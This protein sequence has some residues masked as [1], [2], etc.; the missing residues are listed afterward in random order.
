MKDKDTTKGWGKVE[1]D[2]SEIW[3][4]KP[5]FL[6]EKIEFKD[7]LKLLFYPKKWFLYR[8]IK[9][10]IRKQSGNNLAVLDVGCGTGASLVD[11]KKM[12]GRG[13]KIVGVDV[14]CLQVDLAKEKIK[15]NGVWAE[16][17][18][19]DGAN[20]PFSD[21]TFD[22]IYTSDVLG[23]V[24]NVESWLIELNRVLKPGGV[25]AMFSESKLGRHAYVRNYLMKNGLN[26]DPHA[27][28][29]ISLYSKIMLRE[30]V[31]R[32]GFEIKKMKSVF[33]ASFLVHPDEFYDK[34]QK[35]NPERA[36]R[37]EGSRIQG[38]KQRDASTSS[39][40]TSLSIKLLKIINKILYKIKKILHPVST[41]LCEL[42]GLVEI[43]LVGRF[44]ES[45]GYI[46]F[47][48]KTKVKEEVEE[49]L[50]KSKILAPDMRGA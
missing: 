29:H 37:V 17:H 24:E 21:D 4:T 28:Y 9:S 6:N 11:L 19:Y 36:K 44:I 38:I 49:E 5:V 8:F 7:W 39:F 48:Q 12:F 3:D 32:A 50:E 16:A 18:W 31:E 15:Q 42:Y 33:W 20:L 47:A 43:Y 14:V 34:L 40:R 26:I 45:Q 30:L 22:A 35:F 27:K 2:G 46:I 10:H 23:H 41:V 13:V 1:G 25:L